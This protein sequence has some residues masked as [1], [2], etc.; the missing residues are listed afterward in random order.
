M[1]LT[2]KY[3]NFVVLKLYFM[4]T[5]K[6]KNRILNL[7]NLVLLLVLMPI[8]AFTHDSSEDVGLPNR[9]VSCFQEDKYGVMWIGTGR[10][11]CRYDGYSYENFFHHYRDSTTIASDCVQGLFLDHDS[12]LWVATTEGIS[13]YDYD[14]R[15]FENYY[16]AKGN[17]V[18]GFFGFFEYG[19]KLY[20]YGTGGLFIVNRNNHK[21]Y[22]V[23]GLKNVIITCS[24]ADNKGGMWLGGS[25]SSYIYYIN[26]RNHKIVRKYIGHQINVKCML[27]INKGK[28]NQ[29]LF[30]GTEKGLFC[31]DTRNAKIVKDS[32][33]PQ[34][35]G[36]VTFLHQLKRT[37][38]IGTI[39]YGIKE[40]DLIKNS[41]TGQYTS[42]YFQSNASSHVTC[43][44]VDRDKNLWLGTFDDGYKIDFNRKI[45][46]DQIL[47]KLISGKFVTRI[48]VDHYQNLW[49]GTRYSGLCYYNTKTHGCRWYTLENFEPF[50][51]SNSNFIQ[52][53]YIDSTG[54]IWIACGT[55]L[56]SA[57]IAENGNLSPISWYNTYS[58]IVAIA[59]DYSH[60]IWLGSA[61]KGINVINTGKSDDGKKP[62]VLPSASR[63]NV[64][65]ILPLRSG[66]VIYSKFGS[67]LFVLDPSTGKSIQLIKNQKL[68]SYADRTVFIYADKQENLWLGTYGRGLI[69]YSLRNHSF[70]VYTM[71]DGLPCNDIVSITGDKTGCIWMGT[72]YG[73]TRYNPKDK[74]FY[75][76]YEQDGTGG[77]QFHEKS[78]CSLSDGT[79]FF[80]GNHGLT[81]FNSVNIASKIHQGNIVL[82]DL[83]VMNVS[84][85]AGDPGSVLKRNIEETD[86]INLS[87]KQNSFS[88]DYTCLDYASQRKI[89]YAY[90]LEGFD[91][92]WNYVG[93]QHRL[94]YSN[95]DAGN[96]TL[97]IKACL[98]K[99]AWN[100]QV[101]KLKIHVD[102]APW[103][104][105]PAILLYFVIIACVIWFAIRTYMRIRI[106]RLRLEMA[107]QK[108]RQDKELM[109]TKITFFTNI[110]HELRTPLSMIYGPLSLI[111]ASKDT[112]PESRKLINIIKRN[113]ERLLVLV[114]QLLDVGKI[115]TQTLTLSVA[116][117]DVNAI[118]N[119]IMSNY[120]FLVEK[121]HLHVNCQFLPKEHASMLVDGDKIFK[122]VSNLL[123][124]AIKYTDDNG[125][126]EIALNDVKY[127]NSDDFNS[128][129]IGKHC[130]VIT[131]TDDGMGMPPEKMSELF[132]RYSR[133]SGK[134]KSSSVSGYGI[135]L[136][137]VKNL[138][139]IHHGDI[140]AKNGKEKG[141]TF[142]VALPVDADEYNEKE[143]SGVDQ[144][145]IFYMPDSADAE[146]SQSQKDSSKEETT[147]KVSAINENN[148]KRKVLIVED[149]VELGH[150]IYQLLCKDYEVALAVNGQKGLDMAKKMVPDLII[151]D[152]MMPIM[153]GYELCKKVKT[154]IDLS[155]IPVIILTAKNMI[156]D[157]FEG[158]ENGA[159]VYINKPFLPAMLL[160]VIENI[161]HQQD[162]LRKTI[163]SEIL[164]RS[165]EL[166]PKEDNKVDEELQETNKKYLTISKP[167]KPQKEHTERQLLPVDKSFL[168]KLKKYLNDNISDPDLNVNTLGNEMCMSRTNFYRKVKALTGMTPN[169][170]LQNYRLNRAVEYLKSRNYT[171]SEISEKVGFKTQSHFSTSFKK[172]IGMSPSEYLSEL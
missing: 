142:E 90:K 62:L 33:V 49:L 101:R 67:G 122:I 6:S 34:Y 156:Q 102:V 42:T 164:D 152:V 100:G 139:A 12:M 143:K 20:T 68:K 58:D 5:N 65:F 153:N 118:V 169:D 133:F 140:Y 107:E 149:N 132:G 21:L 66:K 172:F 141:M 93:Q 17:L 168:E 30:V 121:K 74:S 15:Q 160:K 32:S 158:Y 148:E 55:A 159:D 103:L 23:N 96:Y 87:Y 125:Y 155:H 25:G 36:S 113:T 86:K 151:T 137:Y 51:R 24:V 35:N 119:S 88:L 22:P 89:D 81:Y 77:N 57:K 162:L 56:I 39:Y 9:R 108:R 92:D 124:N 134:E 147:I 144:Q 117:C 10:G 64:T 114:D 54:K 82:E 70:N 53:Q 18:C 73:I 28:N 26:L 167:Q 14:K 78:L 105:L 48:S 161:F 43:Y 99:G 59:E 130:L 95:L 111:S 127:L 38:L 4:K 120:S 8:I 16:F 109:S 104:S 94:T 80:G 110:S 150:F 60:N 61:Q 46:T 41:F 115:E 138:V 157:Q 170:L 44:Y 76:L 71:D 126:I 129:L 3:T 69:R 47:N 166:T 29:R 85:R 19:D 52:S 171:M 106:S 31:I 7:K 50:S 165:Q 123:T 79:L 75:T 37:L 145:Q 112:S 1:G 40:Y 72:A 27:L 45:N 84:Q 11:L 163:M 131:V 83:K 128:S 97:Y 116:E 2:N 91:K 154:D 98:G 13:R 146:Y 63:G 136:N 135:G